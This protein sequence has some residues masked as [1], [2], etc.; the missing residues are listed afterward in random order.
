[1]STYSFQK[2][3]IRGYQQEPV[4]HTFFQQNEGSRHVAIVFAGQNNNCQHPTL[5][6]PTR[7]LLLRGADTL[8]V[9]YCLRPAF[10][11]FSAEEIKVCIGAD[12]I[13]AY[14]ALFREH[15]YQQVTLIGKSLGTLAMGHLLMAFP[16]MPQ[17]QAIWLTPLLKRAELRTQIQQAH[18]RSLFVI[19]TEDSH[20]DVQILTELQN[21]TQGETLAIEGVGHLLETSGGTIP[22]LQ[23]MEQIMHIIQVFLSRNT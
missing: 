1:M 5:Y 3:D 21:I 4:P 16:E 20:Y 17:V 22:S 9:D 6:Y 11:T 2:L 7:E 23:V 18:P 13:A 8:L 19:G 12:T 14:Q 10:S 15:T